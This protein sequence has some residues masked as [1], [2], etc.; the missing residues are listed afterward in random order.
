MIVDRE[1]N[2]GVYN[3]RNRLQKIGHA[4]EKKSSLHA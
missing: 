1:D 4:Y 2:H 3:E